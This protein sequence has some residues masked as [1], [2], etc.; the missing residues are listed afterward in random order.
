MKKAV[1]VL[2][3]AI[4]VIG[5]AATAFAGTIQTPNKKRAILWKTSDPD[6]EIYKAYINHGASASKLQTS[7]EN[8]RYKV[9]AYGYNSKKVYGWYKGWINTAYY[10]D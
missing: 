7:A 9:K 8:G 4:L 6:E 2:M 5:L 1:C 3:V 10:K